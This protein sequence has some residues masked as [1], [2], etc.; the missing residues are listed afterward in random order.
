MADANGGELP[1]FPINYIKVGGYREASCDGAIGGPTSQ[2]KLW[3]GFYSERQPIPR[4][5]AYSAKRNP[6]DPATVD[7]DEKA[8]PVFVESRQGLV[9]NVEFGIY[10][11]VEVA[12]KL[13]DWLGNQIGRMAKTST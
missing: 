1:P 10:M 12:Q 4:V 5:V 3:V 9:R 7:V 13:H 2:A 6:D 8:K 11:S